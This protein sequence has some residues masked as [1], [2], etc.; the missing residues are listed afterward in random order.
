MVAKKQ[1]KGAKT[2]FIRSYLDSVPAKDIVE[3]AKKVGI[4]ITTEYVRVVDKQERT[5]VPCRTDG[6]VDDAR[7]VW[8]A[9]TK[10]LD[11]RSKNI[12]G[13]L[14]SF[15]KGSPARA[16]HAGYVQAMRDTLKMITARE[17]AWPMAMRTK[18]VVG[19]R[20]RRR[21]RQ[22]SLLPRSA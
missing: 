19:R 6:P 3:A 2:E 17:G 5:A 20:R 7:A 15:A 21:R 12:A 18:S 22:R 9:V 10:M 13:A 1:I 14:D 16:W 4:Q 11:V 8:A